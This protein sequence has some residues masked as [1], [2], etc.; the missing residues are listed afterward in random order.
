MKGMNKN[1]EYTNEHQAT[2]ASD[3]PSDKS[4]MFAKWHLLVFKAEKKNM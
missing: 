4:Q 3:M 1:A 2:H